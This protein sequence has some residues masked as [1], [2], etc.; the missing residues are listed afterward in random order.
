[1]KECLLNGIDPKSKDAPNDMAQAVEKFFHIK[2]GDFS[3]VDG[4][5]RRDLARNIQVIATGDKQIPD[6]TV[7]DDGEGQN[8]SDFPNT[9]LSI[10][11]NNKVGI[12]F[13]QGKYNMGSTGAVTF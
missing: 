12:P 5:D 1:M 13:V 2:N 3:E 8:P 10:A 11:K 4:S 6:I 7:V 9:F